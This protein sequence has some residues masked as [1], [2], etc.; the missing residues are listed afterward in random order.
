MQP[1]RGTQVPQELRTDETKG[2]AV[3]EELQK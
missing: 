1:R 3:R 2:L